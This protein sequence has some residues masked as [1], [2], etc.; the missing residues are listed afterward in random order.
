MR[1]IISVLVI[2][3]LL[4]S[5]MIVPSYAATIDSLSV[6]IDSSSR[7][8]TVTGT[9]SSGE[10]KRVILRITDPNGNLEYIDQVV[11]T[12]GGSFTMSYIMDNTATGQYA[13]EA[14]GEDVNS[15]KQAAFIYSGTISQPPV[16]VVTPVPAPTPVPTPEPITDADIEK[17]ISNLKRAVTST[18][19]VSTLKTTEK[20]LDLLGKAASEAK[21]ADIKKEKVD[22]A[23]EILYAAAQAIDTLKDSKQAL[24]QAQILIEASAGIVSDA[25]KTGASVD[26][27]SSAL[28][29]IGQ[30]VLDKVNV[31]KV[32]FKV[33]KTSASVTVSE[34]TGKR[35]VEKM[36]TIQKI[37]R[38]LNSSLAGIKINERISPVLKLE[39]YAS[40]QVQKASINLPSSVFKAA[41]E[42]GIDEIQLVNPNATISLAPDSIP[43]AANSKV[44]VLVEKVNEKRLSASIK[45][46]VKGNQVYDLR[47]T[48]KGKRVSKSN[49]PVEVLVPYTPKAGEDTS[50]IT[51]FSINSK[52]ELENTNGV[53]DAD[54][55]VVKFNTKDL[56][57]FIIKPIK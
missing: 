10:G 56:G 4:V 57:R 13:V 54:M 39:A 5:S 16:H 45:E 44:V 27:I 2:S 37:A 25:D 33:S 34:S 1:K 53:Y 19:V 9:I 36:D 43:V 48:M 32:A 17:N 29:C 20:L 7:L 40:P 38:E 26:S 24:A 21:T 50:K 12:M 51:A 11:S 35:L 3:I 41:G 47:I 52:G 18:E 15:V 31:Q 6:S 23:V 28:V 46:A 22:K 14:L 8:V 55:G 30:K 49:K 42:K